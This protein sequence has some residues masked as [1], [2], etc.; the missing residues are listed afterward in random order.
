VSQPIKANF[1]ALTQL[2][3]RFDAIGSSFNSLPV[4]PAVD[5]AA[6][7]DGKLATQLEAFFSGW[8]Q[9][10]QRISQEIASV[11]KVVKFAVTQYGQAD[12]DVA[13]SAAGSSAATVN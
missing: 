5:S 10:R 9:G 12:G 8:S 13:A 11:S 4:H 1:E 2:G 6:L 3:S 7:G